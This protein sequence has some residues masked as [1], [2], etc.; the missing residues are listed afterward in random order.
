VEGNATSMID[1]LKART[2]YWNAAAT[3][4]DQDFTSTLI[5]QTRRHSV[6]RDLERAF[7][8]GQRVL[9]L[10][11]GTGIDAIHLAARG[12][13]VLACDISP[14]MIQIAR[15]GA[16]E[17][18]L[19]ARID[20]RVLPT[21]ELQSLQSHAPFDGAF[22][23]F[24]GLNCVE[25]LPAVARNLARLLKPGAPFLTCVIGRF[26]PWEIAWFLAHGKPAKAFTRVLDNGRVFDA[27]DLKIQRPS[28]REMVRIFAP[29]FELRGW[30]GVGIAVPPSYMEGWARRFPKIVQLLAGVD[31]WIDHVPLFRNLGDCVLLQ[32]S[33]RETNASSSKAW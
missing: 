22:S 23:N 33:R 16:V 6:W 15:Q 17:S 4:Y 3:K 24:S 5:G 18:S 30:R 29:D 13:Q 9:E 31:N 28:V 25:D 19:Q 8:P 1:Q 2:Q 27:G 12:I 20:F 14:H 32:F 11:C 21:E 7:C 26:V 10:N